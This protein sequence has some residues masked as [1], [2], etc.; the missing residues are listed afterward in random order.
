MAKRQILVP[1]RGVQLVGTG[2][3]QLKIVQVATDRMLV[4]MGV[5]YEKAAVPDRAYFADYCDIQKA[6]T[7]FTL[8]FGKLAPG[9]RRLRTKIEISFP[10]QMFALQLWKSSRNLHETVRKLV[11]DCPLEPLTSPE[12]TDMAQTFRS[13]NVFMGVWGEDALLDFYYISPRDM[14]IVRTLRR[15]TIALDPV[16][17]VVMGTSLMF[18]FLEKCRPLAEAVPQEDS[19]PAEVV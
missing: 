9:T 11:R 18:E 8:I 7:G 2:P 3:V 12:D 6:R 14:H 13:N 17:R 15:G 1:E 4:E 10:E 19:S 5:D 16:V